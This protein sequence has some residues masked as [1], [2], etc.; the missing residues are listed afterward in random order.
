MSALLG[1]Y[2]LLLQKRAIPPLYTMAPILG[3]TYYKFFEKAAIARGPLSYGS[4]PEDFDYCLWTA[5]QSGTDVVVERFDG[6]AWVDLTVIASGIVGTIHHISLTFD[7]LGNPI[8]SWEI[9]GT[10]YLRWYDPLIPAMTTTNLGAGKSPFITMSCF[11]SF[12]GNR[13]I[14]LVYVKPNM[15]LVYRLQDDR[16]TVEYLVQSSVD[17]ILAFGVT[18]YNNLK[19]ILTYRVGGTTQVIDNKATVRKGLWQGDS[20]PQ[21]VTP[22]VQRLEI[23]DVSKIISD[24]T[25]P[26]LSDKATVDSSGTV[27]SIGLALAVITIDSTSQPNLTDLATVDSSGTVTFIELKN[28][29]I[30]NSQE[31][32][33]PA[34]LSSTMSDFIVGIEEA[35]IQTSQEEPIP[36]ALSSSIS[37][38]SL[39]VV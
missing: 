25:D 6:S 30:H 9:D 4:T 3:T 7:Q 21:T 19:I 27:V 13:Q 20:T 23:V 5:Y 10:I 2:G 1:H 24:V 35:L 39:T 18:P 8:C 28:V 11:N 17:D 29:T 12:L 16:Y 14:Y 31:E 34:A 15:D 36:A 26:V 32:P 38:F 22:E 33:I 37:N